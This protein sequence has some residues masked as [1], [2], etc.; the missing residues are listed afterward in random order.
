MKMMM[1]MIGCSSIVGAEMLH[2]NK[3]LARKV[4]RQKLIQ[5]EMV[6]NEDEE[7][8]DDFV[9]FICNLCLLC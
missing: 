9:V 2:P 4:A 8:K 1:I 7:V 3:A 6:E 5:E